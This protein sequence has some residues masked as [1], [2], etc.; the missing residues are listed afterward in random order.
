MEDTNVCSLKLDEEKD[1]PN[2]F[3]AVYDGHSGDAVAKFAC[4]NVHKRLINE[5]SY[6][7]KQYEIALKRAFIGTDEDILASPVSNLAQTRSGC[8]AVAALL[9]REGEIY[10]ANAGDARTILSVKGEVKPLSFDH[11]P[12]DEVEK[13]RITAAGGFVSW[14]RVNV[15]RQTRFIERAR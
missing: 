10:V 7:E 5:E 14:G 6:R 1:D 4:Q 8:A 13:T 9:T 2:S 3:F 11:K 12:D 15:H